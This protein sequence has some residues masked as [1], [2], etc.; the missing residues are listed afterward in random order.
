[1]FG[2]FPVKENSRLLFVNESNQESFLLQIKLSSIKAK[3][4]N[5][6]F[7]VLTFSLFCLEDHFCRITMHLYRKLQCYMTFHFSI[8]IVNWHDI[9][10]SSDIVDFSKAQFVEM[11]GSNYDFPV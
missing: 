8:P 1:M 3:E 2:H 5:Q 6:S 9:D 10:Y 11:S 4:T 7:H